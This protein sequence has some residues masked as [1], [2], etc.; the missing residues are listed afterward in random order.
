MFTEVNE[1][2]LFTVTEQRYQEGIMF[3][4]ENMIP[5]FANAGSESELVRA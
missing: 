2:S 1:H 3:S 5:F 4:E